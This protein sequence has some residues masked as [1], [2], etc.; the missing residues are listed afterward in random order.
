VHTILFQR[1]ECN[2]PNVTYW[3]LLG[4]NASSYTVSSLTHDSIHVGLHRTTL[5]SQR[6]LLV[7]GLDNGSSDTVILAG[8]VDDGVGSLEVSSS[9]LFGT[10]T[11]GCDSIAGTIFFHNQGCSPPSPVSWSILGSD[12]LS[13]SVARL[14]QDSIQ[15]VLYGTTPGLHQAE[16]VILLNN[17]LKDTV[18][19]L[20][21]AKTPPNTFRPSA[22]TL[23]T[24][25][26]ISCNSISH[27]ISF[28]RSG[29][30]PPSVST[31]SVIGPDSAGFTASYLSSDSILVTMRGIKQGDQ[32][33]K[34]IFTLDNGSSDTVALAGYVNIS[35]SALALSTSDVKTDTLGATVAVPISINGLERPEDVDLVLHY[36]G[37]V[38]YLGSF[39][40]VGAKLDAPGKAWPG[41]S[42]LHIPGAAPGVIAGYAKFNVFNDSNANAHATFDSL[43]VLT[44]ITPCEYSLPEAVTSTI[45]APSGCVIP[46]LSQLVHLGMEPVFCVIPNPSDGNISISSS[47]DLGMVTIV[48]YDMLGTERSRFEETMTGNTPITLPLPDADG[49][50]TIV[51]NSAAGTKDLRV[52]RHR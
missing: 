28:I 7:L 34:L 19:L 25:D 43:N 9:T 31:Y 41:R 48:I 40:P 3:R 20:G 51:L 21:F 18:K 6:A 49:I 35:P 4:P 39:S 32:N 36:D 37:S 16:L 2:S 42:E 45:S 27:S 44:A 1:S 14:S 29:C 8:F 52:V 11:I 30:T 50:Y 15:V 33:A 13:Y 46:I 38:D 24:L 26:T 47:L 10:D 5:G 22:N 12:S 17:G 23:F